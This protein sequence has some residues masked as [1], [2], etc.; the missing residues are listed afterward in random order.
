MSDIHPGVKTYNHERTLKN[1]LDSN[2]ITNK[3]SNLIL[4][5]VRE[6]KIT[7]DLSPTRINK[8]T[9]HLTLWR[10]FL[11]A[12]YKQAAIFDIYEAIEGL[13]NGKNT[14]GKDFAQNTIHDY[15]TVLKPFLLWLIE[16][17]YS[18]IPEKKVKKIKSPPVD[19]ETT[20]PEEL[21]TQEEIYNLI[22]GARNTRDKA[23]IAVLYESGCR[24]GE[25]GRLTWRDAIFD[26]Y[27]VKLYSDDHKGKQTRYSR[28][29]FSTEYLANWKENTPLKN[30]DD[31]IFIAYQSNAPL[32]Y[33]GFLRAIQRAA[34]ASGVTKAT[35]THL[36][37]K[38]RITH[39]ITQNY[40]ESIIKKTMWGNLNTNM[41]QTYVRLSEDDIDNEFLK[42]AGIVRDDEQEKDLLLPITC[43][44]CHTVNAPDSMFCYKCGNPLNEEA[45]EI[46]N[47]NIN[48]YINDIESD[49]E[50]EP[51]DQEYKKFESSA[52]EKLNK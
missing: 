46:L 7:Y 28:L 39:M 13:K 5:Y 47:R 49:P 42:H 8:I 18:D 22:Q 9:T 27:G 50:F 48:N 17:E 44:Q 29:T 30:P 10:R 2:L 1:A 4:E 23:L 25:L 34:K 36:F 20:K 51:L 6:R 35:K 52:R 16:N 41:F 11:K 38:S 32:N 37:R 33:S 43:S 40:Q 19:T 45:E 3:D 31:N 12:E 14:R 24:I 15:I 26:E 21:L